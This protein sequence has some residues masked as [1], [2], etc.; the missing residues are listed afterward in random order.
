MNTP[1]EHTAD[2][3]FVTILYNVDLIKCLQL[4]PENIFSLTF[5]FSIF[6]WTSLIADVVEEDVNTW[7]G[8]Y[9][10]L[11]LNITVFFVSSLFNVQLIYIRQAASG[12]EP[13]HMVVRR[14]M[15]ELLY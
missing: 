15:I 11:F 2:A 14:W 3:V 5:Y 6:P 10:Y 8:T 7:R 13:K 9:T 1:K 12:L 4:L